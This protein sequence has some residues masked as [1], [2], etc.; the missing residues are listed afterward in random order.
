MRV[1][2]GRGSR[3]VNMTMM[4]MVDEGCITIIIKKKSH[5]FWLDC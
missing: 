2:G 5:E 1:E 4:M 3:M